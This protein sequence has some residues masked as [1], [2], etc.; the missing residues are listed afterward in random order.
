MKNCLGTH[1]LPE[2]VHKKS[3]SLR[4]EP[5]LWC[6]IRVIRVIRE[7]VVPLGRLRDEASV[8][9]ADPRRSRA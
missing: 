3:S 5:N 1:E 2:A 9:I 7:I 6:S 4:A 8:S